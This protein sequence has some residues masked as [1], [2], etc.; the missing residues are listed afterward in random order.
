MGWLAWLGLYFA[1][2]WTVPYR[3]KC[4]G[5]FTRYVL[6][7][8]IPP[9]RWWMTVPWNDTYRYFLWLGANVPLQYTVLSH[10][11]PLSDAIFWGGYVLMLLD[12]YIF[13]DD[14]NWRRFRGWAGNKVK[15]RMELPVP[16][17]NE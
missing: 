8:L 9:R 6:V 2:Q 3:K 1:A 5:L 12:D 17:A 11:R 14:N 4:R 13:G 7:R 15:W 16:V 10:Q